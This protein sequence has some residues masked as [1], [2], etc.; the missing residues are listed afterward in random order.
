MCYE[1]AR[2]GRSYYI[3]PAMPSGVQF[4]IASA[5]DFANFLDDDSEMYL[6]RRSDDRENTP[7]LAKKVKGK[8]EIGSKNRDL[9]REYQGLDSTRMSQASTFC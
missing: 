9:G 4:K 2:N 6:L 5:E 8:Q 3:Y 1:F 7:L